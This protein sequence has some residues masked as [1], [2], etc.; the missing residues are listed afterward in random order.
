MRIYPLTSEDRSIQVFTCPVFPL[1]SVA[2]SMA[3]NEKQ[4]P[5]RVRTSILTFPHGTGRGSCVDKTIVSPASGSGRRKKSLSQS[6]RPLPSNTVNWP[7]PSGMLALGK[8]L[9]NPAFTVK[10]SHVHTRP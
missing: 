2:R 10:V 6:M 1:Q 3:E 5:G 8:A 4:A 7:T 9:R